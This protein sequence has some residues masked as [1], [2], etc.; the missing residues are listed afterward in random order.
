MKLENGPP[1]DAL[2]KL[3]K[4]YSVTTDYILDLEDLTRSIQQCGFYFKKRYTIL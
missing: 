2:I 4:F 3:A 1:V